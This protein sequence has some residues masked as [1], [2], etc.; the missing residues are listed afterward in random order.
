MRLADQFGRVAG[1]DAAAVKHGRRV[2]Q[3]AC[4]DLLDQRL[5]L[6]SIV[7][8]GR[9][10]LLANRPDGLRR[11]LQ[12]TI[13]LEPSARRELGGQHVIGAAVLALG[14]RLSNADQRHETVPDRCGC[15]QSDS[16][17]RF[18]EMLA[19][20]L[21]PSS[22]RSRPQSLSITGETSP[23]QAPASAQCMPWSADFHAGRSQRRLDLA[24]R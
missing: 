22:I 23:V 20:P 15:L 16:R 6:V 24:R 2:R 19:A 1:I 17:I 14:Q 12:D 3:P 5:L 9:D 11:G 4:S 18:A 13:V 10:A 7:G 21:W 8:A